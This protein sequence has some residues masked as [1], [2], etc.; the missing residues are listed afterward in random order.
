MGAYNLFRSHGSEGMY[1]AVPEHRTVP[2]FLHAPGWEFS[3]KVDEPA[4]RPLGFDARAADA[5]TRFNGFHLF[6]CFKT[7]EVSAPL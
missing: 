2:P 4:S 1:C 5:G 7:S 6:P 3:G